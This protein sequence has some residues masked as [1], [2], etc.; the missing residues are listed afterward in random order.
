VGKIVVVGG[1]GH[2]AVLIDLLKG[3]RGFTVIGYTDNADRGKIFGVPYV[4]SDSA[5]AALKK[6]HRKLAGAL[7][8]GK[9]A[10]H[11]K[12]IGIFANMRDAGLTLPAIVSPRAY[13]SKHAELAEGVV[14][15]AGAVVQPRAKI[16]FGS[17]INTGAMV[18]HD[19]IIGID[20][21]VAPGA[22]LSGAAC[23]GDHCLIGVGSALVH[24]VK[25]GARC[26]VGAGAA[27]A[28]DCLEQGKYLGVPAR[29]VAE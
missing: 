16:G 12:R 24:A 3:L 17:I 22:A 21:H 20:V 15:M 27:V 5:L 18:D 25:V 9:V 28:E 1:G 29:K 6:K 23:V 4:G 10:A 26:V 13:V 2:A 11:D 7:G 14:V 8:I 19:C